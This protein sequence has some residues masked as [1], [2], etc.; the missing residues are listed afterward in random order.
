MELLT[1][2]PLPGAG[3]PADP[4]PSPYQECVAVLMLHRAACVLLP[5]LVA[6]L[7][8]RRSPWALERGADA[9]QRRGWLGR[10]HRLADR[11]QRGL[12]QA[13]EALGA[14]A[15]ELDPLQIL[16]ALWLLLSLVWTLAHAAAA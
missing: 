15:E 1:L 3:L 6:A 4:S 7:L 11:V 5:T 9:A 8:A 16:L 14:V 13:H 12:E 2:A 10:A